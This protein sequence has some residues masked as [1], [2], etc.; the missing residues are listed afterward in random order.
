MQRFADTQKQVRMYALSYVILRAREP[1]FARER[2]K[3]D[4][5]KTDVRIQATHAH[6]HACAH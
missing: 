3:R 6:T 1:R 2:E 4:I 5:V